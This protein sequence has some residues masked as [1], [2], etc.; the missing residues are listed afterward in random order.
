MTSR[1]YNPPTSPWPLRLL[2]WLFRALL[3]VT[4]MAATG[5][6]VLAIAASAYYE[7]TRTKSG[8]IDD[9]I[10][11]RVPEGSS[12]ERINAFLDSEGIEYTAV[13]PFA[14]D[15]QDL[16]YGGVRKGD[17][18]ILATLEND[19]YSLE[20]V[21][22]KIA[23]VLDEAGVLKDHVVYERS[24]QPEWLNENLEPLTP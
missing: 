14:G 8:E 11:Q 24:Y 1:A 15:D 10:A 7:L 9:M 3:I 16:L 5:V 13:Q 6:A 19:G 12:V 22:I 21:D 23:F 17:Q 4:I 2:A 18:V 20:L